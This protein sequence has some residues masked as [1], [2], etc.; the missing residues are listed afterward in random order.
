MRTAARDCC[1]ESKRFRS[2]SRHLDSGVVGR[3]SSDQLWH[4]LRLGL[5]GGCRGSGVHGLGLKPEFDS[6]A[7][8]LARGRRFGGERKYPHPLAKRLGQLSPQPI[9]PKSKP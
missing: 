8:L 1:I 7:G 3:G 4:D 9:S 2:R 5:T 6:Q